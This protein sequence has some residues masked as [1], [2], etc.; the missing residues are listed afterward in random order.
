M[1]RIQLF[2]F[3]DLGWFPDPLR[4]MMLRVLVVMNRVMGVPQ[5]LQS[6][7]QSRFAEARTVLDLGSGSGGIMPEVHAE[8]RQAGLPVETILS[9]LHPDPRADWTDAEGL[10][11]CPESIDASASFPIEADLTTMVNCFHHM[12][13]SQ[14]QAILAAAQENHRPL[15]IYEMAENKVPTV[16]WLLTLP[17]GLVITMLMGMLLTFKVRP[18]SL[19]QFVLTWIVPVVPICYAWDGQASMARIYTSKDLDALIANLP[20]DMNYQ[21][22]FVPAKDIRPKSPGYFFIGRPA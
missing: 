10:S 2:E 6:L 7:I 15:V 22:E 5:V 12:P 18:F 3:E 17:L 4:R 20:A 14:A 1:K 8:L 19:T 11:Y 9:D 16:I 13:P 21:W